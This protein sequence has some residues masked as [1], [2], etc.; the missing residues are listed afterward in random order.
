MSGPSAYLLRRSTSAPEGRRPPPL[1]GLGDLDS[2]KGEKRRSVHQQQPMDGQR[3]SV[4][5]ERAQ[6]VT[7]WT[8]VPQADTEHSLTL[9]LGEGWPE[10]PSARLLHRTAWSLG[11]CGHLS[12]VVQIPLPPS[13]ATGNPGPFPR[14]QTG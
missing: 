4:T 1:S 12:A 6:D 7:P 3:H 2:A 10:G 11:Q 5:Q 8:D 14:G 9:W 13:A